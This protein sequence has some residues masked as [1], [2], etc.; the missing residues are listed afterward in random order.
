LTINGS[1]TLSTRDHH[2]SSIDDARGQ[3]QSGATLRTAAHPTRIAER[4]T[5]SAADGPDPA[6]CVRI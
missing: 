4:K 2:S 5:I 6:F 3:R 1:V